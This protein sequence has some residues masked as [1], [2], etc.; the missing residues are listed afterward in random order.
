MNYLKVIA[1]DTSN[2][3]VEKVI[4]IKRMNTEI[5]FSD[6]VVYATEND[7]AKLKINL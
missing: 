2:N 3:S 4:N 6:D 7:A 5:N 1:Y